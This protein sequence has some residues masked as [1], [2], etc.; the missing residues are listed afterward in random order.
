MLV[1]TQLSTFTHLLSQGNNTAKDTLWDAVL[2]GSVVCTLVVR[3]GFEPV[4]AFG[5]GDIRPIF[6]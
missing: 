3:T 4:L 1:E 6:M 2:M 5:I